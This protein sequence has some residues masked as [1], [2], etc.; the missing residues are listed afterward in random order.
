MLA[1][2]TVAEF[3][4]G[5]YRHVARIRGWGCAAGN[6]REVAPRVSRA[7]NL[8][9]H[10]ASMAA[11]STRCINY[12]PDS[13]RYV[14]E[15]KAAPAPLFGRGLLL[16]ARAHASA[17]FPFFELGFPL[18]PA[19]FF[20]LPAVFYFLSG[21]PRLRFSSFWLRNVGRGFLLRVRSPRDV[22]AV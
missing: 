8:R 7:G 15:G 14:G 13:A 5:T 19:A 11:P 17:V 9:E 4:T 18:P 12:A 6:L 16:F 2:G 3:T 22:A 20:S 10:Y 21:S 1:R